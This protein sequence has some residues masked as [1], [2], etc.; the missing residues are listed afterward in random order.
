LNIKKLAVHEKISTSMLLMVFFCYACSIALIFQRV[1]LPIISPETAETGL[2]PNDAIYF[3]Q[4]ASKLANDIRELGWGQWHLFPSMGASGNV[5]ILAA[6]YALFGNDPAYIVPINAAMHALGGVLVFHIIKL[7][8]D[9]ESLG[10]YAGAIAGTL[11]VIFPS[12]LSWYG[13]LH[14]DSYAIAGILLIL[15]SLVRVFDSR[16][17]SNRDMTIQYVLAVLGIFLLGIVRPYNLKIC[18]V[19]ISVVFVLLL[20]VSI[21]KKSLRRNFAQAIFL[22]VLLI[23]LSV[24]SKILAKMENSHLGNTYKDWVPTTQATQ[25]TQ[26]SW[27]W[28]NT[29]WLPIKLES[30][31]ETLARSRVGLIEYG[32]KVNAGSMIDTHRTPE[33]VA[34]VLAYLPRAMQ[35]S[36]LAP[37]PNQWFESSSLIRLVATAEMAVYYLCLPGIILLLLLNRR[38]TVLLT[39]LFV[40]IFLVIHGLVIAN[41]GTLYRLR[42]AHVSILMALG[43]LGWMTWV[44]QSGRFDRILVFLKAQAEAT[45][46]FDTSE[47]TQSKDA[48]RE[49]IGSSIAVMM[50]TLVC[51]VGF[52]ARDIMMANAYGFGAE[53]D[54]FFI[55]LMIPMFLVAV[56]AMPLGSAFVPFYL[57]LKE[58]FSDAELKEMIREIASLAT[59]GLTIASILVL[60]ASPRIFD[61]FYSNLATE[62]YM[63]LHHLS[64]AAL[65]LLLFSGVMILGNAL[66][67]ANGKSVFTSSA[68]LI[69]PMIAIIAL[70]LFGEKYGVLAAL[71]GMVLGQILNLLIVQSR[72]SSCKASIVPS[73]R[74]TNMAALRP[75]LKQYWPLVGSAV[76][77]G[78]A[79]PIATLLAMT[80]SDGAVSVLNLGSKVV[81]FVTGLLGAVVTTVML[82]YFSKIMAR[83]RLLEARRE[84]SFFLLTATFIAVPLSIGIYFLSSHIVDFMLMGGDFSEDTKGEVARVMKYSVVQLPFFVCNALLLRFAISTKHVQAVFVITIF[85]LIANVLISMFFMSHMGVPGIALGGSVAMLISTIFLALMLVR[86]WHIM[87]LDLIIILLNWMLF[88]TLL[89]SVHFSNLPSVYIVAIAY[90][91]LMAGYFRSLITRGQF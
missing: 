42:Y 13:Q 83:N 78:I 80:L 53:L 15:L 28:R 88:I 44:N 69:V 38:P 54:Y 2:L 48:R 11:F 9:D 37:F 63:L 40:S 72:L 52:F 33:S 41:M 35:I 70:V 17:Q 10:V 25:A 47:I 46:T 4:I 79:T 5:S 45:P 61:Q 14:K 82:P 3:H 19:A 64:V 90:I 50:L 85:G 84:L 6:V 51:F 39:I 91:V 7:L 65:P 89:I 8:A 86:H 68:Q 58:R 71:Y 34:D 16:K 75:L 74:L 55:A 27:E 77:I 73:F 76:F 20:V 43:V 36:S 24:A 31:I 32:V 23:L 67:N 60:L 26:E 21:Y 59:W 87:L 29:N 62:N 1:L 81:L 12:A 57:E 49:T 66:L 22:I 18:L 56:L 30:Q